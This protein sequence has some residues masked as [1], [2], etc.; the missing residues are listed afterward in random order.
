[1]PE[2][3]NPQVPSPQP[4]PLYLDPNISALNSPVVPNVVITGHPGGGKAY[5][6]YPAYAPGRNYGAVSQKEADTRAMIALCLGIVSFF[7]LGFILSIPGY[8]LAKQAEITNGYTAKPA[9][10]VNLVSIFVTGSVFLFFVFAVMI[11]GVNHLQ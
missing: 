3:Y 9:K 6:G 5:R 7:F 2:N 1:M 8:F 10:I 4:E 11:A